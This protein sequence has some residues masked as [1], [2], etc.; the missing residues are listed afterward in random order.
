MSVVYSKYDLSRT[1]YKGDGTIDT[2]YVV[3]GLHRD[4]TSYR[5]SRHPTQYRLPDTLVILK[6]L[7]L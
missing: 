7:P 3:I 1:I 4:W 2:H 5:F 6:G